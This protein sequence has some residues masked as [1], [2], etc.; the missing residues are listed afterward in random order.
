MNGLQACVAM[1]DTVET[2]ASPTTLVHKRVLWQDLGDDD[3]DEG[4]DIEPQPKS[5]EELAVQ[6]RIDSVYLAKKRLQGKSGSAVGRRSSDYDER[7]SIDD[8]EDDEE[9]TASVAQS[10]STSRGSEKSSKS[11]TSNSQGI[12]TVQLFFPRSC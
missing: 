11:W 9:L 4:S 8:E 10:R 7:S 3:E 12:S 5:K 2:S 6:R 1:E